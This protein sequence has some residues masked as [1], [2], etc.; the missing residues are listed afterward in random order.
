[1]LETILIVVAACVVLLVVI[2]ASRPSEFRI[3]RSASIAGP[4]SAI[5]DQI[6]DLHNWQA[7]SPWV[8]LDP[9]AK[10]TYDGPRAGV[11]AV[12]A[13]SGN[14]KMGEGRMTIIESRLNELIR[15]K[16]EFYKPYKATNMAEF[17]LKPDGQQTAINWTMTGRN[18]FIFKAIGL[19]MNFDKMIGCQFEKGLASLNSVVTANANNQHAV[20]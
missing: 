11:G 6:N 16:L 9:A 8:K 19:F 14:S 5:F 4:P 1:M 12:S 13:W 3:T 2:V 17:S 18:G 20:S 15:F 10:T 7:W